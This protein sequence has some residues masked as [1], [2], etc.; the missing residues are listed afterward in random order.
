[1]RDINVAFASND[2]YIPHLEIALFSILQNNQKNRFNIF[3]LSSDISDDNKLKINKICD[4]YDNASVHFIMINNKVFSELK[5]LKHFSR[6]MYSRYIL[7]DLL[8]DKDRVLYLDSDTLIT[9]DIAEL[10]NTKL[11]N[12][13]AAGVRD[14]GITKDDLQGYTK[15]LG[16]DDG[17]YFNSGVLLL[18]LDQMRKENVTKKLIGETDRLSDKLQHPDQDIINLVMRD[19][20]KELPNTWNYQD[21]DRRLWPDLLSKAKIIHYTTASKPWNTPNIARGY[22]KKAHELYEKYEYNYLESLHMAEKI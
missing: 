11:G 15:N 3:I 5:V 1:M 12:N 13:L 9:G 20:I 4:L 19:R 10:Y 14:I 21:E 8:E 2:S 6:D 18:N 16:L 22:N 7:P 17:Q